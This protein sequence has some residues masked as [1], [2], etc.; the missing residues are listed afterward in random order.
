MAL[1][2]QKDQDIPSL[3]SF[4]Q[5]EFD[6]DALEGSELD[7]WMYMQQLSN[8]LG[9]T[10]KVGLID[11][12]KAT[13]LWSMFFV[14]GYELLP[15]I[16]NLQRLLHRVMDA[17]AD[18]VLASEAD[19][20]EI[21]D[22]LAFFLSAPTITWRRDDRRWAEDEWTQP[23]ALIAGFRILPANELV[24]DSFFQSLLGGFFWAT[25]QNK[26]KRCGECHSVYV[27]KRERQVFCSNRCSNRARNKRFHNK[28]R[29]Q[30]KNKNLPI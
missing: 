12:P 15:P 16:A 17:V 29:E 8:V 14:K 20:K 25:S 28:T 18:N 27:N 2:G 24:S 7:Q 13:P 19:E 26:F 21:N 4:Y 11:T 9:D 23:R 30:E 3:T 6:D 1:F 10:L 22:L 5:L